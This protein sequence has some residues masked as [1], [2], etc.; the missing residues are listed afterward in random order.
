VS[1][2]ERYLDEMF[3][4]LAG[5]G[6]AGRRA[7][8]ETED[9]LRLAVADGMSAGLSAADAEREA[10]A[11]FGTPASVAAALRRAHHG[12]WLGSLLSGAWLLVGLGLVGLGVT[13]LTAT[14][15]ILASLRTHP[16]DLPACE[17]AAHS[18]FAGECSTTVPT[19]WHSLA[20]G[21]IVLLLGLAALAGRRM[22]VRFAGLAPAARRFPPF[23]ASV[24]ALVA[25]ANL[26]REG[27]GVGINGLLGV[28]QG[29]GLALPAVASGV[30][31]LAAC[32]VAVVG[33][34]QSRRPRYR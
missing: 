11:R 28:A 13:Y 18:F 7:L 10:V 33:L 8:A 29:P 3:D 22:A 24:F 27:I 9:H 23:A 17:G 12:R 20:A 32:T 5:T 21:L 14:V 19:M 6:A 1:V 25:V 4:R 30:A 31:A 15:D 34:I 16:E 26:A 2:V